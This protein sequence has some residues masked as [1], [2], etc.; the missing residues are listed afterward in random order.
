M[1]QLKF[2]TGKKAGQN[3]EACLF[4]FRIGREAD[5]ALRVEEPGVWENHLTLDHGPANSIVLRFGSGVTGVVNGTTVS[6][7]EL[8]N[9]DEV[10]MGSV[11]LRLFLSPPRQRG[12]RLR[13]FAT[14]MLIALI[15]LGEVALVYWLSHRVG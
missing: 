15:G 5:A 10:D 12:L 2:L 14:W 1:I 3:F 11:K 4:P 9:G 13:E 7:A 8:K 6:S